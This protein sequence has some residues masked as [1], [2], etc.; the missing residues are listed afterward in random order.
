MKL[1]QKLKLKTSSPSSPTAH[2]ASLLLLVVEHLW[3]PNKQEVT[4]NITYSNF[5]HA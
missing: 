5:L 4:N 1:P 3:G 2:P